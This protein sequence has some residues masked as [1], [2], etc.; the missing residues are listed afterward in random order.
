MKEHHVNIIICNHAALVMNMAVNIKI[1]LRQSIMKMVNSAGLEYSLIESSSFEPGAL[2]NGLHHQKSPSQNLEA[3]QASS[4]S[5][6]SDLEIM[7]DMLLVIAL[8]SFVKFFLLYLAFSFVDL[9]ASSFFFLYS[10]LARLRSSEC[11][12]L[13]LYECKIARFL[14]VKKVKYAFINMNTMRIVIVKKE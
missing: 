13:R 5:F 6:F 4:I 2:Q 7:I 9:L 14:E 1:I 12:S 3:S 8:L 10:L 11:Y